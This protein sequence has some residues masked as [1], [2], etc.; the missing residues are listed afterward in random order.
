MSTL[1]FFLVK[2]HIP[3]QMSVNSLRV[4]M[5]QLSCSFR[6][7]GNFSLVYWLRRTFNLGVFSS[8]LVSVVVVE[9]TMNRYATPL[10][11]DAELKI[12]E[13]VHS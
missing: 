8:H 4:L 11:V 5:N 10:G 6:L 9:R 7:Y 3:Q 13:E 12:Y 2:I 1:V